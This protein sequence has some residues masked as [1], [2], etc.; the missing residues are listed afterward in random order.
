MKNILFFVSSTRHACQNRLEGIYR[1][2]NG[3]D[4]HVQVVERAFHKVNVHEMLNFWNPAGIIAECGSGANELN[5]DAFGDLPVV[6][7]DADRAQRGPGFYV[8]L[9]TASVGRLAA[10]HLLSLNLPH[11][12]YAAFRMP[13]FWCRERRD[14]Y[15]RRLAERKK[16]CSVL[17]VARELSPARRQKALAD[18]V[19]AL[20]RPCGIFA[21]N[22]LTAEEVVNA[23]EQRGLSVPDE[24][25]V[26]GVDN[27]ASVC[28]NASVSISSIAVDFSAGGYLAA[29][30]LMRRLENPRMRPVTRTF[31]AAGVV[32]RKSTMLLPRDPERVTKALEFIRCHACEG[33]GVRDV[34]AEMGIP[35]RTAELHFRDATGRSILEEIDEWRFAKVF[36]LLRNPR[37]Q[38]DA[39]PDL[40]G[41]S[42]A[43]AL[44]KAFRL[45]TGGSMSDWRK[46]SSAGSRA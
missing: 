23:C 20:P 19:A 28:E 43:V 32:R 42:T 5:A 33:I 22:D 36:E 26:L 31:P 21:A 38:I 34:V 27:D 14:A 41:F 13:I 11:Y 25:C 37:Q 1:F 40:C 45:R 44:R 10:E 35:R 12:A 4:Y 30:L 24:V 6:Y 29:E 15:V 17:E 16:G 9:D 8:G 39:I 7:F 18:W 2:F 46:E 3:S